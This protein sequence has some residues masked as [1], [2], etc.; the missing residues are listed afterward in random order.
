MAPSTPVFRCTKVTFNIAYIPVF[1]IALETNPVHA[2]VAFIFVVLLGF[3]QIRYAQ[4][5]N[6]FQ[7]H[8]K[9][10]W[11]CIV[12]FLLYCLAFLGTLKFGIRVHHF[13]TLMHVFGSLSLISMLL[14]LLPHTDTWESL[15]FALYTLCFIIHV[16]IIMF[17]RSR[18]RETWLQRQ[19]RVT[20]PLLP[21]TSMNLN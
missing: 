20:H 18:F 14:L 4:N 1:N 6:P 15:G 19:R 10:I 11:L 3:L 9:T 2:L 5:P 13:H 17:R 7:L 16:F 8:P 21:I 12:T